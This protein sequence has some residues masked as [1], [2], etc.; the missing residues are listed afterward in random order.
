MCYLQMV[1]QMTDGELQEALDVIESTNLKYFAKDMVAEF[2]ALKG[3]FMGLIN[4]T[5][6]ANK[7]F[8]ASVQ[9]QDE[10]PKCWALW[11]EYLDE[12]FAK[13]RNFTLGLSALTC[14]LHTCRSLREGKCRKYLARIIYMMSYDDSKGTLAE[15]RVGTCMMSL[16]FYFYHTIFSNSS[17]VH[18]M[19]ER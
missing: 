5:E 2:M 16:L 19:I 17:N 4:H 7:C 3:S 10:V 15:V 12:L 18:V 13:D 6:A 8:S 14:Y 1:P 9:L 11:G